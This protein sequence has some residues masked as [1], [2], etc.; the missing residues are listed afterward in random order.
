[1]LKSDDLSGQNNVRMVLT[2]FT[3]PTQLLD[4]YDRR[5]PQESSQGV[6]K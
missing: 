1:M 6:E 4:E 3:S 5:T 2:L